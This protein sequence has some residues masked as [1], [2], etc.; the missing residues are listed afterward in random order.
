MDFQLKRSITAYIDQLDFTI[1]SADYNIASSFDPAV[2]I[3]TNTVIYRDIPLSIVEE[4]ENG[5]HWNEERMDEEDFEQPFITHLNTITKTYVTSFLSS[6]YA[7]IEDAAYGI[8]FMYDLAKR[9]GYT[10]KIVCDKEITKVFNICKRLKFDIEN[11]LIVNEDS[12]RTL[13]M[14]NKTYRDINM[15]GNVKDVNEGEERRDDDTRS[16]CDDNVGA[17]GGVDDGANA[18]AD[19]GDSAGADG[20]ASAGA[21]GDATYDANID[22]SARVNDDATHDANVGSNNGANVDITHDANAST[23]T[24]TNTDANTGANPSPPPFALRDY[25]Q[26]YI[27]FM[28]SNTRCILK[29]PCGLGKSVIIIYHIMTSGSNSIILV[30]NV[31]LVDQFYEQIKSIYSAFSQPDPEI[32]RISTK[33]KEFNIVDHSKQQIIVCVY[34]SFITHFIKPILS[35]S[36]NMFLEYTNI[37]IDEAHHIVLPSNRDQTINMEYLLELYDS[38]VDTDPESCDYDFIKTIHNMPKL[39]FAFSNLIFVYAHVYCQRSYM[40]S[41]TVSPSNFSLYNMFSAIKDGY[42]CRLNVDI[43]VDENYSRVQI[44]SRD[45][46][47]TFTT[48]LTN[49]PYKS[50]IIYT[51][52][53]KTARDIQKQLPFR[54]EVVTASMSSVRRMKIFKQFKE[55]NIRALLTVNCISEGID[56]PCADTA[57][58]FDDKKSIINIIQCVGRVMRLH[59]DKMSSTLVI[60]AYN[61]DD[62]DDIY[63]NILAIINGELGYGSADIRRSVQVKFNTITKQRRYTIKERVFHKIYEYNEGYFNQ[64]SLNSKLTLCRYYFALRHCV[65]SLD[66]SVKDAKLPNGSYFDLQQFVHDNLYLDNEAGKCLRQIY[67]MDKLTF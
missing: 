49:S 32:H 20:G 12:I 56:L 23:Y 46:I 3:L 45:K 53:V 27:D 8:Q 26:K 51:S 19:C 29:L 2:A 38:E 31:A 1:N 5:I 18:G 42:L 15:L 11:I 52:R 34:N 37:Y 25:Q 65:P 13:L 66:M 17:D 48:Y 57:V 61:D 6:D 59:P 60:P 30:P 62:I 67:K 22:A 50:I 44:V 64:I 39:S 33:F 4:F 43:V 16:A 58:F 40:F 24:G 63:Q 14:I 36:F 54:S 21:D 41:A 10:Y 9:Y 47:D 35:K 7:R 55:H 28:N